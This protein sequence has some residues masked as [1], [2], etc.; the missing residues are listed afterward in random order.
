MAPSAR[1]SQ[2]FTSGAFAARGGNQLAHGREGVEVFH[3]RARIKHGLAALSI[4]QGTLP[5][6]LEAVTVVSSPQTLSCDELVVELFLGQHDAHFAHVG[7][8]G[9]SDPVSCGSA[10]SECRT[11]RRTL[12]GQA[13]LSAPD[14]LPDG[15]W[16]RRLRA[17]HRPPTIARH[18]PVHHH[19][20]RQLDG[21]YALNLPRCA[22]S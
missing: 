13:I 17:A 8:G 11:Q 7:A 3:D 16:R 14:H 4:R 10:G 22:P 12:A 5:S 21:R 15:H 20:P 9:G 1:A 6:G 18:E 19:R 2:V